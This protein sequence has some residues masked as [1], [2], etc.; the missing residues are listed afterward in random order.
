[1]DHPLDLAHALQY[2]LEQTAQ[3]YITMCSLFEGAR[4][5]FLTHFTY[6]I[7]H[8]FSPNRTFVLESNWS[9]EHVI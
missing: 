2:S 4:T 8:D 6:F 1:M 7:V 5:A 9:F 3:D